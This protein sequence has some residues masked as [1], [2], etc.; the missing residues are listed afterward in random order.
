M[1]NISDEAGGASAFIAIGGGAAVAGL[2]ALSAV[3]GL[4]GSSSAP[5]GPLAPVAD[6]RSD[7]PP[8]SAL[9]LWLL[10]ARTAYRSYVVALAIKD[11]DSWSTTTT[12]IGFL[13]L[14]CGTAGRPAAKLTA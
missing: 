7:V 6:L 13:T 5:T 12:D 9:R 11:R 3:A 10:T 2:I 4:S 14:T 1:R 8:D